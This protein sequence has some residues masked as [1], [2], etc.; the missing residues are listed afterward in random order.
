MKIVRILL[1]SHFKGKKESPFVNPYP[2]PGTL[3]EK[4]NNTS[5]LPDHKTHIVLHNDTAPVVYPSLKE[6]IL[7]HFSLSVTISVLHRLFRS[8]RVPL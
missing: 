1:T 7:L 2:A 4:S 8:F 5:E 3:Y 6:Y